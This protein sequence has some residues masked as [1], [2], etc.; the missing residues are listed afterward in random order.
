MH[1]RLMNESCIFCNTQLV[2][3]IRSKEHIIP[4]CMGGKLWSRDLVCKDCNNKFGTE[5]DEALIK[6]FC[7]I[8]YPLRLYN[9]DIKI[10]DV[11]VEFEGIKYLFTEE[12]IK[13][14]DPKPIYD[15]NGVWK[16]MAYPSDEAMRKDLKKKKKKDPTIDIQGTVDLSRKTKKDIY[17]PFKFTI[18]RIGEEAYRCCGKICYE[19]LYIFNENYS[20]SNDYFI[21]FV[22]GSLQIEDYPICTWYSEYD[23]FNRDVEKIYNIIVVEGRNEENIVIGYFEGYG[24]LKT[25]M[26]IDRDYNGDSFCE[27]YYHDLM[28]NTY[29]F[30]NPISNI[31]LSREEAI[32]LVDNCDISQFH[33]KILKSIF[34]T[35]DK[36]RIYPIKKTLWNLKEKISSMENTRTIEN[37]NNILEALTQVFQ[38]YGI[39]GFITSQ[40]ESVNELYED[41]ALL[42]KIFIHLEYLLTYFRKAGVDFHIIGEVV[43]KI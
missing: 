21:D 30:Y 25:L 17:G 26:V 29:D 31:P 3:N 5:F 11:E 41:D 2:E 12:G 20:P 1:I 40:I 28:E 16:G 15:E 10:K 36:A 8:M 13:L 39:H 42:T 23:L 27:G 4:Q 6:R 19:F 33:E 24:C 38:K 37:L 22:S 34:H 14:K 32:D 18:D 35:G 43:D 7:L 9:D